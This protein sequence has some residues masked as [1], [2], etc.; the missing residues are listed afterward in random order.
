ML[1]LPA[2]RIRAT[3]MVL[4]LVVST[5]IFN[6]APP[7]QAADVQTAAQE[8]LDQIGVDRGICVLIASDPIVLA[9]AIAAKS[10]LTL[11]VQL[12]DDAG[13]KK[14][15]LEADKAGML[16]TRI[17]VQRGDRSQL[18]LADNLADAVIVTQEI[19]DELADHKP[20]L[21]RVVRPLG[22]VL[23]GGQEITKPYP[24]QADD[25]THAYHGPDN[26]PQSTDQLA[27]APYITQFLAG[28]FYVPFPVV[29][30]TSRG[31]IFKA[32]GHVGYKERDWPWINKLVAFNGYN[33][34]LLWKRPLEEG[35]NIHRNTMIATPDILYLA[36]SESCKLLDTA[37]GQL[38]D[39]ISA[40]SDATG[41][42]WKW[43]AMADGVLYGLVGKEEYR[44]E[45]IQGNRT[46]AGWPWR[47]MT[48]GY[49]RAD[50]AWGFGR[51]LFAV[52][53]KTKKVLWRHVEK[54]QID[55]R[56]IVM[57]GGR[58]YY[59]SHPNFLGGL[60][61]RQGKLLWKNDA[62]D[63]LE[64][65][66]PH[67]KAQT[68]RLGFSSTAYMKC[69]DEA[70]YF[71]G[72]QRSRLVAASTKDGRLLWQLPHGNYQ[73]VLRDEGLY[74]MG[75]LGPSR[76]LDPLTGEIRA[77]LECVRGN[78][79][80]A[81][82]TIDSIFCRGHDHAG[83]LRLTLPDHEPRRIALMR[84]DCH[85]GVIAA[86]GMLYWGPWMCDCSLSLVGNICL[87]PA[88]DFKFGAEA[89][90]SERLETVADPRNK[91]KPLSVAPG[92]WPAYRA[93]NRRSAAGASE[94][95]EK[96]EL[97]WRHEPPVGVDSTAPVT[98]GGMA[99][100]AGSDGVVRALDGDGG[101]CI[102]KAYTSGPILYPPAIDENRLFVGSGDG[103]VYAFEAA[104][105]EPLWRFRAAPV[106]RKIATYGRLTSTWPVASGVLVDEGVVYAA[107]GIAS[108][109]GT[110]VYALDAATGKIRWQNNSSGHISGGGQVTGVS[111]QG[112]L[113]LHENRLYMAGGNVISPA[114]YDTKDGRCLNELADEWGGQTPPA[115]PNWEHNEEIRKMEAQQKHWGKAPRGC[116]LFLVD[117]RV[118]AFD[119]MLYSPKQYW[120][121]RYFPRQLMQAGP[122]HA[123]IRAVGDRV[124]RLAP[125]GGENSTP[126]AAWEIKPMEQPM[127][128]AVGANAVLVAG[129]SGK[130]AGAEADHVLAAHSLKDGSLL[131]SRPLPAAPIWWGLAT[132]RAGRIFAALQDGSVIGLSP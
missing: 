92:D 30:V 101:K 117:G 20:E 78:C 6:A 40:P 128:I 94:I 125:A 121:G 14:C 83:T 82:G 104:T 130:T 29:T 9:Q 67:H 93:D 63:L 81:T 64:A 43:M 99:F 61:A 55:G 24:T 5:G 34:T 85:D 28:P 70:V 35:F 58:I 114:V 17:Y 98:A 112:H 71:A 109:D 66:G 49:D 86:G 54:E 44:D 77:Y 7:A 131:W 46:A 103:F 52:D 74:A 62:P 111:V 68:A 22:K 65:I 38:I 33:G 48:A 76:L 107:A 1:T 25:W 4:L 51:T 37:T 50:Y 18:H 122:A 10:E 115:D 57:K 2:K 118:T 110:H 13:V 72:P 90:V 102:W 15:R 23:L 96:V 116:E 132:D 119:R 39:E 8:C 69:G 47:P 31:R 45:T 105:G 16:G 113:L 60:D 120:V 88:G 126:R 11:Y 42:V 32:F 73:L 123:L 89:S 79:T 80:R 87:A 56:A 21:L 127:A 97:A 12:P 41:P 100:V 53:L 108:Y 36:D 19:A 26:N 95:P 27:R 129:N 106:Q 3:A 75:R 84:P 59:Y 124:V 91:L